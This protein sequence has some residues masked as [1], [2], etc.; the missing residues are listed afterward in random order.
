MNCGDKSQELKN[1]FTVNPGDIWTGNVY[2]AYYGG[3]FWSDG[4]S[5]VDWSP[6]RPNY[7]Y[8]SYRY[9]PCSDTLRIK[10]VVTN[11]CYVILQWFHDVTC[12]YDTQWS[13]LRFIGLF[14]Q[15]ALV[16]YIGACT[17]T[18][19]LQAN[20]N[21]RYLEINIILTNCTLFITSQSKILMSVHCDSL[22]NLPL[23]YLSF[24]TI[25]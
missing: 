7:L 10:R 2:T 1:Y 17:D 23:I 11:H 8:G 24:L 5:W 20:T 25:N 4:S 9:A 14:F 22:Y 13:N 3:W 18:N 15:N 16:E 19:K 21:S 6:G 12:F